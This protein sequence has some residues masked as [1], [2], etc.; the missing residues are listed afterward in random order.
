MKMQFWSHGDYPKW[1]FSAFFQKYKMLFI[2]FESSTGRFTVFINK[3][4]IFS[5]FKRIKYLTKINI[6]CSSMLALSKRCMLFSGWGETPAGEVCIHNH[7][8]TTWY[9]LMSILPF[10][11]SLYSSGAVSTNELIISM[12]LSCKLD[13]WRSRT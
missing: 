10:N 8:N 5:P 11:T 3:L 12:Q 9:L 7:L 6:I 4:T 1:S 2:L 13:K